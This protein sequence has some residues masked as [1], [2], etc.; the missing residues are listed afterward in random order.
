MTKRISITVNG[1]VA[2]AQLFEDQAPTTV[3]ALWNS[4]PI[5]DRTIQTRW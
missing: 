2:E 4:L 3:E 1:A 5:K